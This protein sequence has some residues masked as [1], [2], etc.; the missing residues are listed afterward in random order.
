MD[1]DVRLIGYGIRLDPLRI[2]HA[3]ALSA[4]TDDGMWAG[5][6]SARPRDAGEYSA[7]IV[8]QVR[9]AD[10]LAFAVVDDADGKV[11]GTTS[12]YDLSVEQERVEIG[13]TWYG[14]DYW[15]GHT[16]PAA[17]WLLLSHSF[18][19]LDLY[20]VGLRCDAG[21]HAVRRRSNVSVEY[22]KRFYAPTGLLLTAAGA[23]PRTSQYFDRSGPMYEPASKR[24]SPANTC[25]PALPI[26]LRKGTASRTASATDLGRSI[27]RS[28]WPDPASLGNGQRAAL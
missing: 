11:L 26:P 27:H 5:M 14:R 3:E 8:A 15:G 10:A 17:K 16:N 21:T 9:E 18:D 4:L 22:R 12:L 25:S 28:G 13:S 19:T 24:G 20:R 2:D 1:H 23:I 7:H 6:T